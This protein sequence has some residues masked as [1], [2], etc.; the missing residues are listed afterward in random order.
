MDFFRALQAKALVGVLRPDHEAWLRHV[1]RWYARTF[2]TPLHIVSELPLQDV[3]L[4]YYEEAFENMQDI[5]RQHFLDL[6]T[7]TDEERAERQA[8]EEGESASDDAFFAKLNAE[9]KAG[10]KKPAAKSKPK[11][12]KPSK[13]TSGLLVDRPKLPEKPKPL[14]PPEPPAELPELPEISMDFGDGNLLGGLLDQ[15]PLAP[16][17]RKK[18]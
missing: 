12:A 14:D 16:P 17:P 1:Y 9:V 3:V 15:D 11:A 18:P 7:E 2:A 4:A 5:E 10:M 6:L 8:K 13:A